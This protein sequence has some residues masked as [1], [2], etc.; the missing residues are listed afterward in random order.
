MILLSL[1]HS[2]RELRILRLLYWAIFSLLIIPFIANAIG[3]FNIHVP[4][5]L[6]AV[7][8][9]AAIGIGMRYR[10]RKRLAHQKWAALKASLINDRLLFQMIVSG[11]LLH[12]KQ[13]HH[14][15]GAAFLRQDDN[16]HE[17]TTLHHAAAAGAAEVVAYLLGPD[18]QADA[19]AARNNEFTP[20]HAAAMFGHTAVCK[21]LLDHGAALNAQTI[22]QG[23]TPLHSAAWAGHTDTLRLLVLQGADRSIQNYRGETPAACARRRGFTDAGDVLD[24]RDSE[25]VA[26]TADSDSAPSP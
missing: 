20:L 1:L 2:A 16:P 3:I 5:L 13:V 23:Y 6:N 14:L 8:A 4:F 19:S 12:L 22:P 11:D 21:L 26:E 25:A 15:Y 9:A 24:R 17:L 18:V 10:N 7:F